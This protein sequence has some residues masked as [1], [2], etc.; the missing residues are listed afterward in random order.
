MGRK[1]I[2]NIHEDSG[3]SKIYG[4]ENCLAIADRKHLLRGRFARLMIILLIQKIDR[5]F[6]L[7]VFL[8]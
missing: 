8:S 5:N 3:M 4:I 6:G 1:I 2:K 7:A